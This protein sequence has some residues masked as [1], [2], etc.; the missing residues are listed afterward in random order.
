[1]LSS[2]REAE[3]GR[4]LWVVAGLK[5]RGGVFCRASPVRALSAERAAVAIAPWTDPRCADSRPW[6]PKAKF[7]PIR[8]VVG[9]APLPS[10]S[11]RRLIV[12]FLWRDPGGLE[13]R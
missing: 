2:A 9:S 4:K 3:P 13:K 5:S 1:M 8:V 7:R 12:F 6:A 11:A 10:R